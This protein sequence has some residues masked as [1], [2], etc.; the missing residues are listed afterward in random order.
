MTGLVKV[1]VIM[2]AY[3]SELF[4]GEAIESILNQTFSDFELIVVD[5]GSIDQTA[6]IIKEKINDAPNR[7][8]FIQHE[9][10]MGAAQARNTGLNYAK[11]DIIMFADADDI[12]DPRR[13][14]T[15]YYTL[16]SSEVDLVFNDCQMIG[17]RGEALHRTKGYPKDVNNANVILHSLKRNHFWSSLVLLK[18]TE[19][20]YFDTSLA[21]AE[22]FELF[23]RLFRKGYT[24]DIIP[25]QLTNYRIHSTNLSGDTS[26]AQQ[27][28]ANIMVKIDLEKLMNR[29]FQQHS[30]IEVKEAIA[31]AYLWRQEYSTAID[32]LT[33]DHLTAEGSFLLASCYIK[34]QKWEESFH[35]F[36]QLKTESANPAVLNNF[37][38]LLILHQKDV[39]Q[40]K[41]ILEQVL[42]IEPEY[43]DAQHNLSCI[44]NQQLDHLRLTERP[45]REKI[46]AGQHYRQSEVSHDK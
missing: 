9:D 5:D 26:K 18:K 43:M 30:E 20:L 42:Q 40:A 46:T 7:I 10:N 21:S 45:L 35:I 19:D 27:A 8:V 16:L 38:V 37:A 34:L 33:G 39:E 2:P 6:S 15:A 12:Q 23:F 25:E 41:L 31:A 44:A 4:I 1:S 36:K 14:E 17:T 28:I 13:L 22:D 32:L 24:F 11:A 3:N 29:L